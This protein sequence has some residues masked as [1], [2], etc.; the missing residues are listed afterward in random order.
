MWFLS[1]WE[2]VYTELKHGVLEETD[3]QVSVCASVCVWWAG[4]GMFLQLGRQALAHLLISMPAT[5]WACLKGWR[6]HSQ[7]QSVRSNGK[8]C[9]LSPLVT[10]RKLAPGVLILQREWARS[11]FQLARFPFGAWLRS[12]LQCR[13]EQGCVCVLP[14][15]LWTSYIVTP[16]HR[17]MHISVSGG[18]RG[19]GSVFSGYYPSLQWIKEERKQRKWGG[20]YKCVKLTE[21]VMYLLGMHWSNFFHLRVK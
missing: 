13:L 11:L 15:F 14:S 1:S 6:I 5:M 21:Q 4:G 10:V 12:S 7:Q 16:F 8:L 3:K 9:F 17:Q 20:G 2:K 18:A 19:G